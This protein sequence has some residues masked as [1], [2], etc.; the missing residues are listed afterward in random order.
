MHFNILF[1][2]LFS[3]CPFCTPSF[4]SILSV[5]KKLSFLV[6]FFLTFSSISFIQSSTL[7]STGIGVSNSSILNFS[8]STHIFAN[9][10]APC[11]LNAFLP[12]QNL[13][14]NLLNI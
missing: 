1:M 10:F 4:S 6:L 5:A 2:K 11:S 3:I 9:E 7:V 13:F 12:L 14:S 8:L